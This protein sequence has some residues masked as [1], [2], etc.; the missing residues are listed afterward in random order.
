MVA[1]KITIRTSMV[2]CTLYLHKKESVVLSLIF[3]NEVVGI[4]REIK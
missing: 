4:T 3:A 2:V 1:N